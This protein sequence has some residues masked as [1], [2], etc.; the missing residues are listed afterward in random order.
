[1]E[2][3][4][5]RT[6]GHVDAVS[7]S[8]GASLAPTA[9]VDV[10][11]Y[12]VNGLYEFGEGRM[13]GYMGLGMGA[14][15]LHPFIP[16]VA[17]KPDTRV[18]ANVA[19]GGKL[20]LTERLA[21]RLDGRY[22]WRSASHDTGTVVC[23][24][25]GCYALSTDLYSSSEVT[26]GL[27]YRFGSER[28]R[29]LPPPP[30]SP[31]STAVLASP[32]RRPEPPERFLAAAGEIA[33]LEVLPWAFSRYVTKE[34]WAYISTKTVKDNFKT[35]FVFDGDDFNMNQSMHPLHGSLYFNAARSNGYSYWES[36]AFTMAGS[37]IWE[38]C[39][40]NTAPSINDLV[41]TTLGGM[42]RGEMMH[43]IGVMLRDNGASGF[44]RFW[45]ELSGA[46]VDPMGGFNRLVRGEMGRD[47]PNPDERFP[48]RFS[49]VTDA[50]YRH[51]A[52][53]GVNVGEGIVSLSAVY[54]DAFAGETRKPF[55]SFLSLIHI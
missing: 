6:S 30:K 52:A 54:G 55:D 34:D 22:R 50:G 53:E 39:M 19:V 7:P 10:N 17:T 18:V 32:S 35:G 49:F 41:N 47:F 44:D 11:T 2:L 24:S 25:L 27:S 37:L 1:M 45:R 14:M 23:G 16:G 46:I 43:R 9:P 48:S 5:S 29:D 21:L 31:G 15:T 8:T 40:E 13:R 28:L 42:S 12:E 51:I 4:L 3:T 38:C 33:L 26:A 20:Y 36:G